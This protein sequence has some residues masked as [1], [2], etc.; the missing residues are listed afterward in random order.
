MGATDETV[1]FGMDLDA[2]G[3][4]S[5]AEG[6]ADALEGLQSR[7]E[8]DTLALQKMQQAM[9]LLQ[10][11]SSTNI[12]AFKQ[13]RDSITA[14]KISLSQATAELLSHGK[15]QDVLKAKTSSAAAAAKAQEK[16]QK[17]QLK[18][19]QEHLAAYK[20]AED[21]R[22]KAS[23]KAKKDQA[24]ALKAQETQMKALTDS[25]GA[26]GG[27]IGELLGKF[28]GLK[29]M[30]SAGVMVAGTLALAAAFAALAAGVLF[31]VGSLLKYGIA[32]A[33]ARRT[34]LLQLEG[35]TKMRNWYGLAAGKATDLQ[36]A[37]DSV[38]G[39]VSL[40][41]GQI[42]SMAQSLYQANL[43]GEGL[44][45]ALEAVEVATA[46]GGE[47]AGAFYRSLV[48]GAARSGVAVKRVLDDVRARYGSIAAAQML[49]LNVQADKFRENLDA[50]FRG[51]KIEGFLKALKMVTDLF[52]LNTATG[53]ALA[54]MLEVILNPLISGIEKAGP[55]AKRFFQ[56][57]V[58]GAQNIVIAIL[59]VA[60]AFKK[61]FGRSVTN[62]VFN[63][64]FALQLGKVAVYMLV[65]AIAVLGALMY[66]VFVGTKFV[67]EQL[68]YAFY[69]PAFAAEK[70]YGALQ[71]VGKKLSGMSWKEIGLSLVQGIANGIL[72]GIPLVL[73]SMITLGTSAQQAL[74]KVWDSHS[75]SKLFKVEGGN[76]PAGVAGGVRAGIPQV[77]AAFED[78]GHAGV[79]G[80]RSGAGDAEP[81]P[82]ELP[83]AAPLAGQRSA[84][85]T[86][87]G[88]TVLQL[89]GPIHVHA[90]TEEEG[91]A[92]A[93]GFLDE[94]T[95]ALQGVSITLG[96]PKDTAA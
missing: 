84:P 16:L 27:P 13:L 94:L 67:V 79:L 69:L 87:S 64:E 21:V 36:G 1:T 66:G 71:A 29:E 11:G 32:A 4:E 85:A 50:L 8:E 89:H 72:A 46:A 70:M 35:L 63:L 86:K 49:S 6:S 39:S 25:V 17:D 88:P 96:V 43:R 92:A 62:D 12:Q 37:I 51:V 60:L 33:D 76:A 2:S 9:R 68:A 55:L 14:K 15:A 93:K 10:G 81:A 5:S 7:I 82:V 56:G 23:D 73:S 41:R 40:G 77:R 26:I 90:R 65:G 38:S 47:S 28:G 3:L 83:R 34:E 48:T 91:K 42:N 18:A 53:R 20:K 59:Q 75:P 22:K 74:K 54:K 45:Q 78:L 61:T 80:Y 58:L 95:D 52:S 30:L 31:A 44:K 19:Q 24:E 57:M